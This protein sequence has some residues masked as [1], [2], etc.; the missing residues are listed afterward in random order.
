MRTPQVV[1]DAIKPFIERC[2][3]I[4]VRRV[5]DYHGYGVYIVRY[6]EGMVT[7]FPHLFFY[8]KDEELQRIDGWDSLKV[9]REIREEKNRRRREAR[10]AKKQ[11]NLKDIV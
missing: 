2:G 11:S 4:G 9:L 6:P 7:G 3:A 10:L 8:K 5:G 1:K